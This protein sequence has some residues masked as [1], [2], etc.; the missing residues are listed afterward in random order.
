ML[1]HVRA[2]RLPVTIYPANFIQ[3]RKITN[4]DLRANGG[5]TYR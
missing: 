1:I 4:M 5:I 3:A 2:G